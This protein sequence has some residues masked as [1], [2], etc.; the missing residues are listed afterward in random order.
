MRKNIIKIIAFILMAVMLLPAFVAC[1]K[2]AVPD[3][4]QLIAC[5]GDKFRLYVPQ[6]GW[7]PNVESGLSGAFYSLNENVSVNVFLA[8]DAD[9]LDIEEYWDICNQKNSEQLTG[10]SFSGK[11]ENL[12]LGGQKA[13]KYVYGAKMMIN[14]ESVDY[15]FMQ[16]MA[17][18]DGEM[19]ILL[20]TS[21]EQYYDSHIEDIEGNE[22]GE[23][24]IPYFVFDEPYVAENKK[25]FSDKVEAPEG[26]KLVSTDER[27]YRLFVPDN[28]TVNNRTEASAAYFSDEDKSNVSLQMYM[29]NEDSQTVQEYFEVCEESYKNLF[30]SYSLYLTEDIKMDGIDAKKYVMTVTSGGVEYRMLQ[31]I[32]KKGAVFYCFTYTATLDNYEKHLADVQ[33]MIENFDIR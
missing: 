6:K 5:E 15:K 33:K 21:P 9:G 19:Y 26:M 10:Y 11:S 22:K 13:K 31:A 30:A 7:T 1:S 28:W 3:G 12:V 4:Y 14:G 32:V 2:G 16:V 20:Y 25:E 24:I 8:D 18:Y 27:A 17:K 29:T 23:G